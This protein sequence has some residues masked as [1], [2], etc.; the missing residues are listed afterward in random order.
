MPSENKR[1]RLSISARIALMFSLTLALG[2]AAA[3]AI[4]YF[5]L[6]MSLE[7]SNREVLFAKLQE[8]ATVLST[9]GVKGLKLFQSNEKNRIVNAPFMI[10]VLNDLGETIYVKPS[11][12]EKQFN[13]DSLLE[14]EVHP[15]KILGWHALSAINDEDKFD[16]LT[17]K[18]DGGY[19]LQ[20][21]KSSEDREDI[22]ES[23]IQI[24]GVTE[25]VIALIS[26]GLGIWYSRR[27]LAPLRHLLSAMH[28]IER[29]DLSKRVEYGKVRDEI[30]DLTETFNRMI[31]RIE[32]LVQV[33]RE[34]LD[35]VA[36]D[37]RTPLTRIRAVAED[38]LSS[39]NSE[40]H[41][42]ALSECAESSAEIS[43]LVDQ[44]M[45]ISEAQAGTLSL[46]YEVSDVGGLLGDVAD[47]YEFVAQ[48]KRIQ[49]TIQPVEAGLQW[50][51]DR[52]RIKQV[53]GNLLDNAIKFSP[54]DS[55][56][57]VAAEKRAEELV[58]SVRDE[59]P[60]VPE[61][62]IH[63]IWDRLYRGDKSRTTKGS[64]LGL[65]IVKSIVEAHSGR[66]EVSQEQGRGLQIS[67]FIPDI[68][69]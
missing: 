31:A 23:I 50:T 68:K 26:I 12:Q 30:Y 22:L 6:Q 13:F 17:E 4:T 69:A 67:V 16:L 29:G 51:L 28:E 36:H 47:I 3:F 54:A 20:V 66:V 55:K 65:A 5:Q 7:T 34:S 59:G 32:K 60:G 53:L 44:L 42:E 8:S 46:K 57:T 1:Q 14:K 10:R 49:I 33:M 56:V 9:E 63:R 21:G 48:E 52:K 19:Y 61:S 38:A 11:V 39:D 18:I 24:F 2:L 45:S 27:S 62:E 15:E 40:Y 37:I 43:N 35:N 41:R 25:L 64:G 58:I